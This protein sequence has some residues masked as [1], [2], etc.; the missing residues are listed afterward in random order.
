MSKHTTT[1]DPIIRL[2]SETRI[3]LSALARREGVHV[4]TVWRWTLRGIRGHRLACFNV[5]AKKFTTLQSYERWLLLTNGDAVAT[6]TSSR[7]RQREIDNAERRAA[8]LG[9]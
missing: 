6:G 5:G 8:E 1:A 2:L 9:V 3:S 4:S 7:Q